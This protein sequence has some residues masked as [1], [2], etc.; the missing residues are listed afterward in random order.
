MLQSQIVPISLS[1]ALDTKQD[2]KLVLEGKL[3]RAENAVINQGAPGPDGRL[4]LKFEKRNGYDSMP[5][6]ILDG[7]EIAS[8]DALAVFKDELLHFDATELRSYSESQLSWKNKGQIVP[9]TTSVKSVIRNSASQTQPDCAIYRGPSGGVILYAW[10]DSLGGVRASVIDEGTGNA[11][12]ADVSL[13]STGQYPKCIELSGSLFVV[14][15]EGTTYVQRR[16]DPE[17]PVV[18]E[19][20]VVL[21]TDVHATTKNHDIVAL[22]TNGAVLAYRNTGGDLKIGYMTRD[23]VEGTVL[24]GFPNVFTVADTPDGAISIITNPRTFDFFVALYSSVSDLVCYGY[25][26]NFSAL[27]SGPATIAAP[28]TDVNNITGYFSTDTEVQFFYEVEAVASTNTLIAQNTCETDGTPGTASN[29]I[30]SVGL[31]SRVFEYDDEFYFLVVHDSTLQSTYFLI[32]ESGNVLGKF[33]PGVG[34]GL[35]NGPTLPSL[36]IGSDGRFILP[37]GVKNKLVSESGSVFTLEGISSVYLDFQ[38]AGRFLAAETEGSLLIAG[39]VL[40]EYDGLSVHE[41]GFHLYPEGLTS[42]SAATGGHMSNGTYQYVAVFEWTDNKGQ[43][44]KSSPSTPLSVTLSGGGALQTASITIPTLRLTAKTAASLRKEIVVALYRTEGSG[45]TFYRV[46]SLSSPTYNSTTADSVTIVDTLADASIL[47]NELL[48]TTG[49]VLENISP[50]STRLIYGQKNRVFIVTA[51]DDNAVQYSKQITQNEGVAFSGLLKKQLNP[52]GGAPTAIFGMDDKILIFKRRSILFFSGE[53]P[54]DTGLDDRLSEPQQIISDVGCVAPNSLVETPIGVMFQSEKGIYL[55]GRDLS[56]SFIGE[57][58]SQFNSQVVSSADLLADLNQVR[59]LTSS[60]QTFCFN[61]M[62]RQWTTFTNHEGKDA[63][64]WRG[65][66][67]YLRNDGTVYTETRGEYLDDNTP[68][69]MILG[70]SWIKLAGVQGF[71]RVRRLNV[72]GDYHSAH[73]LVVRAGY[74]YQSG[75]TQEYVFDAGTVI[76]S[77]TYGDDVLYGDSLYGGDSDGVYQFRVHLERQKCEAVRFEFEDVMSETYGQSY[78]LLELA[79]E[80][81]VKRGLNKLRANKTL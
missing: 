20:A 63:V 3:L 12:Q 14:Y 74:D 10:K 41:Q 40:T 5:V 13:S 34:G 37:V 8:G 54:N 61:Y 70:T 39:G 16:L 58:V 15:V 2:S 33:F 66:Y 78:S 59:F 53:G 7:G 71:Q 6:A 67:S 65:I 21:F 31:A 19:T 24:N 28:A 51:E 79:V 46:S 45:S 57:E 25:A 77:G 29:L 42:S 69:K 44:H 1:G 68:F 32:N 38:S 55:L 43:L 49:G 75:F 56:V 52:A 26:S 4:S 23:G 36:A 60:G 47:S 35:T 11:F 64:I 81:G 76:E 27:F 50:A 80:V 48:Y 17:N 73:Q 22:T 72:L 9:L 30:R 62:L 18:F